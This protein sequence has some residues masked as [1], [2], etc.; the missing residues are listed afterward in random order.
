MCS[1][2]SLHTSR[3]CHLIFF[4][5]FTMNMFKQQLIITN[6]IKIVVE[7]HCHLLH[8]VN[9]FPFE[10]H[11]NPSSSFIPPR[12]VNAQVETSTTSIVPKLILATIKAM[13]T[14]TCTRDQPIHLNFQKSLIHWIVNK[15]SNCS[16]RIILIWTFYFWQTSRWQHKNEE[17]IIFN[18]GGHYGL[19][20]AI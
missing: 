2:V 16:V 7:Q 20:E 17:K 10:V 11:F 3:F 1:N 18:G 12:I 5:V 15:E 6:N 9:S 13:W 14:P 19:V 8:H 4:N